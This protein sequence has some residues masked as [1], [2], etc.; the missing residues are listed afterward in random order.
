MRDPE[1]LVFDDLSSALDIETEQKLWNRLSRKRDTTCLAV[2]HRRIALRR[3]DHIVVLKDGRV[4]AQG[5]LEALLKTSD[6]MRQLWRGE[7]EETLRRDE[8]PDDG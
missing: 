6:E 1:L 4:D 7:L 5:E 2:S 8:T 3:A